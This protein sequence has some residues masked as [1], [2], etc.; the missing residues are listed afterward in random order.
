MHVSL[1]LGIHEERNCQGAKEIEGLK[2]KVVETS[3]WVQVV[4]IKETKYIMF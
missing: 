1:K 3:S 4:K 2:E